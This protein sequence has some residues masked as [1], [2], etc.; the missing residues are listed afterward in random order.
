MITTGYIWTDIIIVL[1][2][3][4]ILDLIIQE[5]F[6]MNDSETLYFLGGNNGNLTHF[7]KQRATTYNPMP[8]NNITFQ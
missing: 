4:L 5:I 7:F 6:W 2:V 8:I 3:L 1:G